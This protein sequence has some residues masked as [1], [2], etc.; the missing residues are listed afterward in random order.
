MR[1]FGTNLKE[2]SAANGVDPVNA[3]QAATGGWNG[4]KAKVLRAKMVETIGYEL[5]ATLY[6]QRVARDQA[7]LR[8]R[9]A[10]RSRDGRA[11]VEGHS[12]SAGQF[13]SNQLIT[14]S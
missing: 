12:R 2:W 6:A 3:K 1:V 7:A 4:P 14:R 13:S 9:R 10:S 5:F 11:S 8:E